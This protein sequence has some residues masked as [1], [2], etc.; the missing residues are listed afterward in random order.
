MDIHTLLEQRFQD[1]LFN[2]GQGPPKS[3]GKHDPEMADL[4]KADRYRVPLTV[5]TAQ[6]KG[7]GEKVKDISRQGCCIYSPVSSSL[8]DMLI[9]LFSTRIKPADL[10]FGF[11]MAGKIVWKKSRLL[12]NQYGIVFPWRENGHFKDFMESLDKVLAY[13]RLV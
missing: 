11:A 13:Y 10:N 8:G 5:K 4:R 7:Q 6:G 9:L 12:K 2:G 3:G 1:I